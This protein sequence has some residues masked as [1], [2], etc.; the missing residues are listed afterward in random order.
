MAIWLAIVDDVCRPRIASLCWSR[1]GNDA[2]PPPLGVIGPRPAKVVDT[3]AFRLIAF[4]AGGRIMR[5]VGVR[6]IP[7]GLRVFPYV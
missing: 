3:I 4:A 7:V 1:W 2:S 5:P 6:L